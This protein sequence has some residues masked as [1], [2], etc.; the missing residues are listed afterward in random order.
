VLHHAVVAYPQWPLW[1]EIS[2]VPQRSKVGGMVEQ[3]VHVEIADPTHPIT[4]GL[5]PFDI[6]DEIYIT[7]DAGEGNHV[8]LTTDHPQ[9][10]KTIAWTRLHNASRVFCYQSGHD[11]V[12]FSNP[13]FRNVL[14]RGI[15]WCA[16]RI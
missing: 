11:D 9:S 10:M 4:K 16:R 12:A 14:A 7:A 3:T 5:G 13:Y 15:Q 6:I 1:G 2:G 8:L